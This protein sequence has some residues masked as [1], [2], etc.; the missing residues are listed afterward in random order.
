MSFE[1]GFIASGILA[2][3]AERRSAE[4]VVRERYV[5]RAGSP[6]KAMRI[7]RA[8]SVP[9]AAAHA[10]AQRTQQDRRR[11]GNRGDGERSGET[12]NQDR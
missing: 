8:E 12:E 9:G 11:Q 4:A 1:N 7:S 2:I 3:C 5:R 10:P 6:M